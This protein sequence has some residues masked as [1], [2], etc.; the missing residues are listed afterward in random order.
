MCHELITCAT[1]L[2]QVYPA[3]KDKEF[4]S[5]LIENHKNGT[6]VPST[7]ASQPKEMFKRHKPTVMPE[8]LKPAAVQNFATTDA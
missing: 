4:L 8:I 1:V 5:N 3:I 2:H 6:N 7:P